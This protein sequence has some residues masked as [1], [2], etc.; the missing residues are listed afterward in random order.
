MLRPRRDIG[1]LTERRFLVDRSRRAAQSAP[2]TSSRSAIGSSAPPRRSSRRRA[3]TG[4]TIADVVARSG[5]SVGAIYTHFRGKD[6]L[7]LLACDATAERSLDELGVRLASLTSTPERLGRGPRLLRRDHRLLRGRAWPGEPHPRVGRGG[8][9]ARGPRH[10]RPP[11]RATGRGGHAAAPRGDHAAA[12]C[13]TGW[14]STTSPA[15]SPGSSMGSCSSGSRP[16]RRI[17]PGRRRCA[18]PGSCSR[19]CCPPPRPHARPSRRRSIA[20]DGAR[21]DGPRPDRARRR[22]GSP[23]PT[24]TR[25]SRC[26]TSRTA[27]ITGS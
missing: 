12:I 24:S 6:E 20:P 8:R 18:G 7:F 26:G 23:C 14:M 21:P 4:A 19:S 15:R 5:L 1:T 22:S 25:R 3:I 27:G 16:G 10:A 2:N 17:Q 13:P 11:A 9:G